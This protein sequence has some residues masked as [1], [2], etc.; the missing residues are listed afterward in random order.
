VNQVP[1]ETSATGKVTVIKGY[2]DSCLDIG[3]VETSDKKPQRVICGK[4]LPNSSMFPVKMRRHFEGVHPD[5]KGKPSDFF[6]RNYGELIK[7]QKII[8]YH[9]KTVNKKALM[10]S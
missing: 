5:C 6:R 4:V 3:F 9:S 2:H 1:S 8:S 10:A 7:V